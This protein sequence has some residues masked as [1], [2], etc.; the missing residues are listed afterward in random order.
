[1]VN[2]DDKGFPSVYK[3]TAHIVLVTKYRKP[4]IN[5]EIMNRLDEIVR[6]ICQKWS[7]LLVEFNG[8]SDPR[9][10]KKIGGFYELILLIY[11]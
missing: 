10:D 6:Q 3:L 5:R 9:E 2:T 4:V 7:V 1:M 8:E 11:D